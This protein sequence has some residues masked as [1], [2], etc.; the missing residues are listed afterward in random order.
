V[1]A[2]EPDNAARYA[3][4]STPSGTRVFDAVA[5]LFAAVTAA[6]GEATGGAVGPKL[7]ELFS[8]NGIEPVDVRLFPVSNVIIGPAPPELW[9]IRREAIQRTAADGSGAAVRALSASCLDLLAAYEAE[10]R[11][12]GASFVEIQNTTL[13]ATVGQTIE[14]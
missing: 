5:Q 13:F 3:N 6:R 14:S 7:A 8:R 2:V 9:K 4:S 10:A 1:V 12:A 11:D